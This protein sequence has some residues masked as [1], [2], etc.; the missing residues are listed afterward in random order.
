MFDGLKIAENKQ[1]FEVL[2]TSNDLW[3]NPKKA[4][5]ILKELKYWNDLEERWK[6]IKTKSEDIVSLSEII[7]E[8]DKE[9]YDELKKDYKILS[10]IFNK[11]H[12]ELV[13]NDKFD[14]NNAIMVV[15]SGTGGT[16]AQDWSEMLLRMYLRYFEKNGWKAIITDKSDGEEVGIKS[17][18]I[19]VSGIMAYGFLKSEHGNT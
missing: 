1:K 6:N 10:D 5:E 8:D 15:S 13:L 14:K 4:E 2:S 16:E 11:A 7:N 3:D 18:T 19:E 9:E 12:I 17:A